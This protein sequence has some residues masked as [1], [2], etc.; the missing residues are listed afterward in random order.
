MGLISRL[1]WTIAILAGLVAAAVSAV[2]G[3]TPLTEQ[4]FAVSLVFGVLGI[5]ADRAVRG[6]R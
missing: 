4:M 5:L 3:R 2:A 6:A 1:V